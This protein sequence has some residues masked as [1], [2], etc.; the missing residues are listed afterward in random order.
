[1]GYTYRPHCEGSAY[2]GESEDLDKW[3][4]RIW[5]CCGEESFNALPCSTGKHVP[6]DEAWDKSYD[7]RLGIPKMNDPKV[8][9]VPEVKKMK[10]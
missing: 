8:N 6:F 4:F 3:D 2:Y 10:I 9:D 1:M 7:F 5:E